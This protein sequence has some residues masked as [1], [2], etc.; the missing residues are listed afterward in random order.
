MYPDSEARSDHDGTFRADDCPS[1]DR[2]YYAWGSS[3]ETTYDLF[4][5]F[6][7]GDEHWESPDYDQDGDVSEEE[8]LRWTDW[9]M[10]GRLF[11]NWHPFKHPTL[12]DVE[13]GGWVRTKNSPPEG[14]LVEKE[15]A[16]GNA[17][18]IYLAGIA[19]Q[20]KI[21]KAEIKD[22]KDGIYQ[23]EF[24]VENQGLIPT[25]MQ[26]AESSEGGEPLLVEVSPN[27]NLEILFGETRVK[28]PRIRGHSESEKITHL[29]RV[30]NASKKAILTVSVKSQKAGQ[31]SKEIVIK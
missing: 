22:K 15:C 27:D 1:C 20:V 21:G 4:G 16:M 28:V 2:G 24:V 11:V 5:I 30:K 6:S 10:G 14:E 25:S 29:V 23:V 3:I 7:L 26:L 17:F 12:G 18:V 13:I 19:P 31:D 8:R 9:E